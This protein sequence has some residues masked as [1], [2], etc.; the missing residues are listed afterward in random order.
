MGNLEPIR[1]FTELD[2]S[3]DN[4]INKPIGLE[5]YINRAKLKYIQDFKLE[6][7]KVFKTGDQALQILF[8]KDAKAI[9]IAR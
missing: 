2:F 1:I 8:S 5:Y 4:L 7:S 3:F 9:S 6:N